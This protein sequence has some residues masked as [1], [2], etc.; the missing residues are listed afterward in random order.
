[1]GC[2]NGVKFDGFGKKGWLNG[3]KKDNSGQN[4]LKLK[5]GD[6]LDT[7]ICRL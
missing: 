5:K 7:T 2:L 6:H 3:L 1:M 4:G